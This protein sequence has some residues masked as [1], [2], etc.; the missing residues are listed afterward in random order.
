M[1]GEKKT[2]GQYIIVSIEEVDQ[3]A[4]IAHDGDTLSVHPMGGGPP[5]LY[6]VIDH[7]ENRR[8]LRHVPGTPA[9]LLGGEL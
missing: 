6:E 9:V 1:A 3:A 4:Q 8:E 7:P 2:R 5:G